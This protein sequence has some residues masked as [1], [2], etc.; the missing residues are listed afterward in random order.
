[1]AEQRERESRREIE[2]LLNSTHAI[3]A[4]FYTYRYLANEGFIPGYN[5]PRL[6][7]RALMSGV[8]EAHAIDRPRFLGL[9]EFG[10]GNVI[11]HEG[12][13]HRV[14]GCVMPAGGVEAR[15]IRAK[16]PATRCLRPS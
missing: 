5:F 6:P 15:I 1:M 10:P 8:T 2:M 4:D 3:E 7:V 9:T 11:Y 16:Q 12:R 14:A 13:K